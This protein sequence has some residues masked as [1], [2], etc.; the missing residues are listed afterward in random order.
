MPNNWR[1]VK[2][3]YDDGSAPAPVKA[4]R[5]REPMPAVSADFMAWLRKVLIPELHSFSAMT[6]DEALKQIAYANGVLWLKA[7]IHAGNEANQKRIE[8]MTIVPSTEGQTN[9]PTA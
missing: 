6:P 5:Q 3:P 1:D 4:E 9:G 2:R 7:V 8:S